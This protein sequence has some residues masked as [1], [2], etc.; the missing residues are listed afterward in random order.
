MDIREKRLSDDKT[1]FMDLIVHDMPRYCNY[2]NDKERTSAL[3]ALCS[4]LNSLLPESQPYKHVYKSFEK[5]IST[6]NLDN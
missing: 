1:D 2:F 6:L 4:L 3:I 5:F